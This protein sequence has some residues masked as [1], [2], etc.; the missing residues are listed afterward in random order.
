L[1]DRPFQRKP[2]AFEKLVLSGF[3][4]TGVLDRNNLL[5]VSDGLAFGFGALRLGRSLSGGALALLRSTVRSH[6]R[7][8]LRAA[9]HRQAGAVRGSHSST[10]RELALISGHKSVAIRT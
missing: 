2:L 9:S 7:R 10:P 5:R 6:A 3:N 4:L 1:C 8:L